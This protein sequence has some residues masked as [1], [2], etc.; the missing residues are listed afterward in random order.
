MMNMTAVAPMT[1]DTL[2]IESPL[3][4]ID[5]FAQGEALVG[6]YLPATRWPL[7]ER[8]RA[9]ARTTPILERAAAQLAEYFAGA[10]RDFEL[11]LAPAG[12]EFQRTVWRALQAIPFGATRS[13]AELARA[14]DRP[15]A[16]RAVGA[17]NGRNPISIVVPCHRVIGASGDLTG[18][19]GGMAAKQWLLVHERNRLI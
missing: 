17:A 16:S 10:R 11:P 4:T 2:A 3:G 6:L 9:I 14:I 1:L 5:L 15:S 19:G 18:Y 13:Y 8:A 12:T 7:P